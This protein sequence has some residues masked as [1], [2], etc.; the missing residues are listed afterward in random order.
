MTTKGTTMSDTPRRDDHP[1]RL[2]RGHGA[3]EPGRRRLTRWPGATTSPRPCRLRRLADE[4]GSVATEYGLLAVVAATI[5]A[6]VLE[7]ATTG[8]ISGLLD[9]VLARV[10]TLVGL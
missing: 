8:G 4:A 5:V 9:R 6:V 10:S 3:T 7:W 1:S 2:L